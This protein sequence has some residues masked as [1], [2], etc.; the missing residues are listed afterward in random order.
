MVALEGLEPG[1]Y[2]VGHESCDVAPFFVQVCEDGLIKSKIGTRATDKI[3]GQ[4]SWWW[5]RKSVPD[6]LPDISR[7]PDPRKEDPQ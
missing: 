4:P 2:L 5:N 6:V 7:I 3:L 1:M